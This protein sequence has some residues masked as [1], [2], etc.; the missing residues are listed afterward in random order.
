MAD[1]LDVQSW[2]VLNRRNGSQ[3]EILSSDVA[4]SY[5]QLPDFVVI[6]ELTH[7]KSEE[8]WVSLFSAAAKR[9]NCVLIAGMNAGF[10]S[11]SWQWKTR[12]RIRYDPGWYFHH[13]DG[14]Q[15]RWIDA[16]RLEEQKRILPPLAFDRL[17]M[18]LWTA[19]TGD[20]L[21]DEDIRAATTLLTSTLTPEPANF[22]YYAGLDLGIS[23]DRCG[24]VLISKN[25]K[26]H[27]LR[28]CQAKSWAPPR[29]GKIDLMSVQN[30]ILQ[31]NERFHPLF[32]FDPYQ[33]ELLAQQ[34]KEKGVR[35]ELIPFA[36]KSLME[37]ASNLLEAF[38]NRAIELFPHQ[39]LLADLRRLRVKETPSGWRLDAARTAAGHADLATAL[40]LAILASKRFWFGNPDTSDVVVAYV[41]EPK[42]ADRGQPPS[43]LN[44][45]MADLGIFDDNWGDANNPW[46][47]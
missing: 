28:L 11:D 29:G 36:G 45:A 13:L 16:S 14:P 27:R 20:A 4:T 15:A 41:D 5:G 1:A 38:S 8:L 18:N 42:A 22:A 31:M 39:E 9:S 46:R 30:D 17:W 23:R 32:F 7:W 40:S 6:D 33:S 34:L 43:T 21:T 44:E 12:E 26:T 25:Y 35:L 47:R 19:G 10:S 37:M 24:L 2:S 3:L